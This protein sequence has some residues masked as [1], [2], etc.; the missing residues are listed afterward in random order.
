MDEF[1]GTDLVYRTIDLSV[2]RDDGESDCK[3]ELCTEVWTS[4]YHD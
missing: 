2:L 4:N 3:M 1:N